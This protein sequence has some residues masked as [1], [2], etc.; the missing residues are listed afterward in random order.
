MGWHCASIAVPGAA[1]LCLQSCTVLWVLELTLHSN[2]GRWCH[3]QL[4]QDMYCAVGFCT[5]TAP[6]RRPLLPLSAVEMCGL[7]SGVW[8][9]HCTPTTAVGAAIGCP[10]C[11]LCGG[12]WNSHCTPTTASVAI[13]SC[14]KLCIA[15]PSPGLVLHACD[16]S[17]LSPE[18]FRFVLC[19]RV[20]RLALHSCDW[21]LR[22][23]QL[24]ADV[25]LQHRGCL[26]YTRPTGMG[27]T[28]C[29]CCACDRQ[30][31]VGVLLCA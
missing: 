12:V 9:S 25:V 15:Q 18:V 21:H 19:S 8:Y 30:R 16:G 2:D 27:R 22:C 3:H 5:R 6:Q 11:V 1:T 28:H 4:S 7:C 14:L 23:Y 13:V 20:L 26:A 17:V 10:T 24:F 31:L 29:C